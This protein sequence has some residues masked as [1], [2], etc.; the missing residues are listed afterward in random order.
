MKLGLAL[1]KIKSSEILKYIEA[2]N[3][4]QQIIF[5]PKVAKR[6]MDNLI[7]GNVLSEEMAIKVLSEKL[8]ELQEV[9]TQE[10]V[11][12]L[13]KDSPQTIYQF[14]TDK[15]V[16]KNIVLLCA[17]AFDSYK[18]ANFMLTNQADINVMDQD[19]WTPLITACVYGNSR[20]MGY[21]LKSG[22]DVNTKGKKYGTTALMVLS[23]RGDMDLL[24]TFVNYGADVNAR[25]RD[26]KTAVS[27]ARLAGRDEVVS[28]LQSIGGQE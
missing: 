23:V 27:L 24:S 5:N 19:G 12:A 16:T 25:M 9:K 26:G 28:Y 17:A 13:L 7:V 21:L 4:A 6:I 14:I 20:L 15:Y 1:W 8:M 3:S 18:I 22:A 11:S 10:F 2:Y